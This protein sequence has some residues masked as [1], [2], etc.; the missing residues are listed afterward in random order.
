MDHDLQRALESFIK[1][2][3]KLVDKVTEEMGKKK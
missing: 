1:A 2:I 3:T